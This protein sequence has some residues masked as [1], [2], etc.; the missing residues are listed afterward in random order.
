MRNYP[1][2]D[3]RID[4]DPTRI[5]QDIVKERKTDVADFNNL[6]NTFISGRKSG[7]IPTGSSDVAA[8]DFINDVNWD[9]NFIY[10]LVNVSGVPEWRRADLG[11]WQA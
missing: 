8:T 4:K 10:V 1:K 3:P 6:T 2:Y 9:E 5:L 11:S 7:K